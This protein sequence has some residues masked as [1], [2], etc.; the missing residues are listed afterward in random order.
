M[1]IYLDTCCFNRPYD[2]Q[3]QIN[4][5]LE[6]EAKLSIQEY[7]KQGKI[8]LAWS[9]ILDYEI[10]QNPFLERKI[11]IQDWRGY[12][13]RDVTKSAEIVMQAKSLCAKIIQAHDALHV[14]CAVKAGCQYFITTDKRL[15]QRLEHNKIIRTVNPV[16]FVMEVLS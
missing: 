5:R 10:E 7:V 16:R 13:S 3:S 2:D 14:A 1:L 12:A 11:A 8:D 4:V 15:I 6:T 9:Y